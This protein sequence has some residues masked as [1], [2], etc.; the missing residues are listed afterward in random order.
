VAASK[1]SISFSTPGC[2]LSLQAYAFVR[3]GS[4]LYLQLI[5]DIVTQAYQI[6]A[7]LE[8]PDLA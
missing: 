5:A 3:G 8:K 2:V 7:K 6:H 1:F 4:A